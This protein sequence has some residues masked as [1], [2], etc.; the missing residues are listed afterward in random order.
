MRPNRPSASSILR[1]SSKK[2]APP[3]LQSVP[4]RV[5]PVTPKVI[6]VTPRGVP[7][8]RLDSQQQT[9]QVPSNPV[10]I[11]QPIQSPI[12]RI[13]GPDAINTHFFDGKLA[14]LDI[15]KDIDRSHLISEQEKLSLFDGLSQYMTS[16]YGSNFQGKVCLDSIIRG[17]SKPE[18]YDPSNKLFA[19]DLLYLIAEK[20]IYE[21]NEE[22]GELLFTQ[23]QDMLTG[24]CPQGRTTRLFQILYMLE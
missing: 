24:L 7:S 23:L 20:I 16:K 18:N 19:E 6:P 21:K 4:P 9:K 11:P 3:K 10:I 12:N 5:V 22:Y 13:L 1:K 14:T 8:V 2:S 15:K 17:T